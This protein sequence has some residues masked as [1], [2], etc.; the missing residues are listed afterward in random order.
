MVTEGVTLAVTVS[1]MIFEVA[2]V[3]VAHEAVDTMV[4]FTISPSF[5]V[6]VVKVM[7]LVALLP[8]TNHCRVGL[9]PLTGLAVKVTNAPTHM[10]PDGSAV[11]VTEGV[12]IAVTVMEMV[13]VAVLEEAQVAFEVITTSTWSPLFNMLEL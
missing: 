9:P 12:T 8:F 3:V 7:P 10:G 2:I 1:V 6:F 11:I 5:R 13:L 4:T